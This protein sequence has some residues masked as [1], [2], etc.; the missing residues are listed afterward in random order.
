MTLLTVCVLFSSLS[1]FAYVI[2][3]FFKP[4]MKS[5]FKRF[6]LEGLAYWVVTLEFLGA[7]GLIVGLWFSTVLSLASL[8]L[9]L[10]MFCGLVVRLRL[11]DNLWISLPAFFYMFLN[12]Y[13]FFASL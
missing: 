2:T 12:G 3:F 1:F 10:L 8:G 6:N 11:K 7:A 5:E 13:I 4:K 9:A